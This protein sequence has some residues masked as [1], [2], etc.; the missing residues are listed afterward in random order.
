MLSALRVVITTAID[1]SIY[2]RGYN[3]NQICNHIDILLFYL[4]FPPANM[5]G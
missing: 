2:N 5:R 1:N 3:C 4:F